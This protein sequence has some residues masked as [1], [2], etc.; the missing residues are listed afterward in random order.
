MKGHICL[1]VAT[2]FEG[3]RATLGPNRALLTPVPSHPH[4]SLV[5]M[6][7]MTRDWKGQAT[8]G[9]FPFGKEAKRG[10]AGGVQVSRH[11][12]LPLLLVLSTRRVQSTAGI[13][14]MTLHLSHL[15]LHS[16]SAL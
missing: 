5:L 1:K 8:H 3:P 13:I 10:Q 15:N 2:A 6:Q 16:R 12:A 4:T 14:L 7:T 9:A 11:A